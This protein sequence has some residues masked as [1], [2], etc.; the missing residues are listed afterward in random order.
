M[1]ASV[2]LVAAKKNL[3]EALGDRM[4]NYLEFLRLW[5]KLK[6][7]R[8]EFDHK[9]RKLLAM[10]SVHLHNQF[11]LAILTKCQLLGSA[12][13]ASREASSVSHSSHSSS[14]KTNKRKRKSRSGRVPCSVSKF[15][16]A[17]PLCMAP[18]IQPNAIEQGDKMP[19]YLSREMV[20]PD[21]GMIHGRLMVTAWDFGL[22]DV[23]DDVVR[24]LMLA[25]EIQLKT[26]LMAVMSRR[27]GYQI[28]EGSF[29]HSMGVDL[30]RPSIR[31]STVLNDHFNHS[32][33]TSM[34]SRG[35]HM[36]CV[37][38][39]LETGLRDAATEI[40][41]G[42]SI[43]PTKYPLNLF[44]LFDTLQVHKSAIPCHAVYAINMERIIHKLWHPSHEETQNDLII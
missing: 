9:A 10:N 24:A 3:S 29:K 32:E 1:A 5:F 6:L 38:P 22:E 12:H 18:L 33:A 36:P 40:S 20:L 26:V 16:A 23:N 14:S 35:V 34:S 11:L 41:C 19:G 43:P 13:T 8:E 2:D 17:N 25:I 42:G 39:S 21:I 37:K 44:D 31:N 27:N 15:L 28:R 4:K 7:T 30:P